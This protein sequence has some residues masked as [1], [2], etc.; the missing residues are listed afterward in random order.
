MAKK[1]TETAERMPPPTSPSEPANNP[2]DQNGQ[3]RP[4]EPRTGEA[5]NGDGA[6][7][8]PLKVLTYQVN[9]DL[10][11]QV[12]VWDRQ[13]QRRDGVSFTAYD[14]TLRKRWKDPDTGEWKSLYSFAPNELYAA[15]HA[16]E[17]AAAVVLELRTA[18]VPF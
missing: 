7:R 9:L 14:V 16:L 1:K 5:K 10:Y 4:A 2:A 8:R 3:Q 11:V 18:D 13:A 12:C 6:E 17:A 15:V